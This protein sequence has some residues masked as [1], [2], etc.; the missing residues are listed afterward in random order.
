MRRSFRLLQQRFDGTYC[1]FQVSNLPKCI[2]R[3]D[4]S[5][6]SRGH[7][8]FALRLEEP[9]AKSGR[10]LLHDVV[11]RGCHDKPAYRDALLRRYA[12]A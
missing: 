11:W 1:H 4:G 8:E 3:W 7:D 12:T 5:D 2:V 6:I 9:V 10:F